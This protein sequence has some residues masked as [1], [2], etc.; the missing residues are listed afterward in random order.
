[1]KIALTVNNTPYE[2]DIEPQESLAEVLQKRLGLHGVKVS[3][4]E[5]ECGACTVLVNGE[6]VTSCIML[7]AQADGKEILTIEGLGTPD[8]LHPIQ[9]AF[10]EEQGFQCGFC[11]PGIILSTKVLLEKNPDPTPE[12]ISE[13]LSGHICRCGAYA[14]I[15][16]AVLNAAQKMKASKV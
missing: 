15:I 8:S 16:R 1:M 3:C 2:V 9:E 10:I 4:N 13:A 7:A 11:T 6:P 12:Q 14:H 5:G